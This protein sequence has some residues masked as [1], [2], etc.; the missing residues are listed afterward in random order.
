MSMILEKQFPVEGGSNLKLSWKIAYVAEVKG[1]T[2]SLTKL[3]ASKKQTMT[4][5]INC[6]SSSIRM[7]QSDGSTETLYSLDNRQ[8]GTS[9]VALIDLWSEKKA[10]ALMPARKVLSSERYMSDL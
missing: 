7:I 4:H 10:T 9:S 3:L 1:K 8:A 5:C 6:D 2:P